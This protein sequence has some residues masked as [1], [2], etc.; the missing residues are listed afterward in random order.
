MSHEL[1]PL[2]P[3]KVIRAF[4]RGGFY[5]HHTVMLQMESEFSLLSFSW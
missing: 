5:V 2:T 1:P 3:K 4:E